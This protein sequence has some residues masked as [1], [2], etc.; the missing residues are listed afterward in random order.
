VVAPGAAETAAG[1]PAAA[2]AAIAV[3]IPAEVVVTVEETPAAVVGPEEAS[4][5][6][7]TD[8]PTNPETRDG[9]VN[10]NSPSSP[11][12]PTARLS[13]P[14]T[15]VSL[16]DSPAILVSLGDSPEILVNL[17]DNRAILASRGVSPLS[18]EAVEVL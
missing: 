18:R 9:E 8:L 14:T 15:P 16:G 6:S 2:V 1:T 17:G 13:S 11:S 3:G 4:R 5:N 12:S 10:P 7:Q